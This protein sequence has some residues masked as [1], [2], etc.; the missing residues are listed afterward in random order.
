MS[1]EKT[2]KKSVKN[3]EKKG[4][5]RSENSTK[6]SN[7]KIFEDHVTMNI[8]PKIFPLSIVFSAAYEMMD[9]A[10][11]V[12]DGDPEEKIL[13]ELRTINEKQDLTQIAK[14]F[15]NQLI[16]FAFYEIQSMRTKGVRE[17]ITK[18]A[19]FGETYEEESDLDTENEDEC[20]ECSTD[21]DEEEISPDELVENFE[22]DDPEGI[23]TPWEEKYGKP[24]QQ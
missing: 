21:V 12:I 7:M 22:F 3:Q 13:V 2:E 14:Q 16:N 19:L 9:K 15:N 10:Y 5:N 17:T 24:P 1:Q 23:A 11:F 6:L 8:N 20:E 18:A 4:N